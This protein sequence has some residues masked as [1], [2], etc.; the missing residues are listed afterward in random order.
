MTQHEHDVKGEDNHFGGHDG[1][2]QI[3]S[4]KNFGEPLRMCRV[5]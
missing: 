2:W 4:G 1:Q 3:H 5:G